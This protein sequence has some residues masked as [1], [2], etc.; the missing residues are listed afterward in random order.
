MGIAV[1]LRRC[2]IFVDYLLLLPDTRRGWLD[3]RYRIST[4]HGTG[5]YVAN[6]SVHE[7]SSNKIQAHS[8]LREL[9]SLACCRSPTHFLLRSVIAIMQCINIATFY[10]SYRGKNTVCAAHLTHPRASSYFQYACIEIHNL[11]Y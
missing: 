1:C 3:E 2:H 10:V 5:W 6:F 8:T 4:S 7:A 11:V 9:L